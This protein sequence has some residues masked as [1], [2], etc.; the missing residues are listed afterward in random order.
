MNFDIEDLKR[1]Y[2]IPHL[3]NQFGH[4]GTPSNTCKHPTDP[5]QQDKGNAFSV[6]ADGQVF[7]DFR[8]GDEGDVVT[9]YG[10]YCAGGITDKKEAFK[11]YMDYCRN[12]EGNPFTP[13]PKLSTRKD[14]PPQ[15][16]PFQPWDHKLHPLTDQDVEQ[17]KA[18]RGDQVSIDG[19]WLMAELGY[20]YTT[21]YTIATGET[22]KAFAITDDTCF[23][24]DLRRWDGQPWWRDQKGKP[25]KSIGPSG[26]KHSWLLGINKLKWRDSFTLNEGS[27]DFISVFKAIHEEGSTTAPLC[28]LG[29]SNKIPNQC[30]SHF[31][32][33]YGTIYPDQDEH[34]LKAGDTWLSQ[35][36][37]VTHGVEVFK[38]PPV[39]DLKDFGQYMTINPDKRGQCLPDTTILNQKRQSH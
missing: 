33:K 30:L 19:I 32:G 31:K 5:L 27:G 2:D 37:M 9:Y 28:M 21:R 23:S 25:I 29:A 38:F 7:I 14:V 35:I 24:V 8:D 22:H 11:E 18:I 12:Q 3:W 4:Y 6:S 1:R 10:L 15:T 36:L 13:R 39:P 34:G 17:L 20:L 16:K 26:Q